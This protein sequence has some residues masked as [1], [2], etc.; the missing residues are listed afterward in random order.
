LSKMK[1]ENDL[2]IK[3]KRSLFAKWA[4]TPIL[5]RASFSRSFLSSLFFV[6]SNSAPTPNSLHHHQR[7]CL[8]HTSTTTTPSPPAV[9]TPM[10]TPTS[11]NATNH[12]KPTT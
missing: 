9:T 11:T 8:P 4:Y 10:P 3:A 6:L 1:S 7:R 2:K 12:H 5:Q